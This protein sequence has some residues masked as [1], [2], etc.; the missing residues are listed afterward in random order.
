M[1]TEHKLPPLKENVEIVEVNA[2]KVS[3]GDLVQKDQPLMEVQA[4]KAALEVL[5]PASGTVAKILV[6]VGDQVKIGQAYIAIGDG[7]A[8]PAKA[9][10][11]KPAVAHAPIAQAPSAAAA[12]AAVAQPAAA[13]KPAP[14]LPAGSLPAGRP[15]LHGGE[16]GERAQ[17]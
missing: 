6:K 13:P 15:P 16:H 14:A 2:V 8:A 1:A 4:D 10:A 12:P 11:A 3:E 7:D 5:S 17:L 9:P